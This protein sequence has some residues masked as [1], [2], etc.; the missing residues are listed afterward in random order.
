[1]RCKMSLND[2][3]Q[4]FE[5]YIITKISDEIGGFLEKS[6]YLC[7]I[8][9]TIAQFKVDKN[10]IQIY[11]IILNN[12]HYNISKAIQN[13]K[14]TLSFGEQKFLTKNIFFNKKQIIIECYES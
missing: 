3:N 11:K 2:Q 4:L 8:F 6:Q 9:G 7:K 1:M 10:G 13:S 12:I 14:I 5:I